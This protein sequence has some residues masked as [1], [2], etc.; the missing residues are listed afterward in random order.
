MSVLDTSD[1]AGSKRGS[2]PYRRAAWISLGL[3]VLF[4]GWLM[5]GLGLN[6][7]TAFCS[8]TNPKGIVDEPPQVAYDPYSVRTTRQGGLHGFPPSRTC[9]LLAIPV[10]AP[11]G[12]HRFQVVHQADY[13]GA[14]A[15][16]LVLC[17][18]FTPMLVVFL[19]RTVRAVRR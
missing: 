19:L 11:V 10:S 16:L 6:G 5:S 8:A 18:A 14:G 7:D 9:Y 3:A 2:R 1:E 17:L 15:Y 12:D 4:L 13:P